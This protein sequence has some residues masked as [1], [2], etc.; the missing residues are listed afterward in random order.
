MECRLQAD[1][2]IDEAFRL[3]AALHASN[4][5]DND[6]NNQDDHKASRGETDG[7]GDY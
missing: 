2:L 5:T 3:K 6:A 1:T 4:A 7:Q